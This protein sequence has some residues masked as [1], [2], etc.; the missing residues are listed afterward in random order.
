MTNNFFNTDDYAI[1]LWDCDEERA[2]DASVYDFDD[3]IDA[4]LESD[5]YT[6]TAKALIKYDYLTDREGL[7]LARAGF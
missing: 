4:V 1:L 5:A 6:E 3:E 7:Q 2:I